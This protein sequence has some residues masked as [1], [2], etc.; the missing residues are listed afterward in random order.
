MNFNVGFELLGQPLVIYI[1]L[2]FQYHMNENQTSATLQPH[3]LNPSTLEQLFCHISKTQ[4]GCLT[5]MTKIF[6]TP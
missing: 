1:A 4:N 3:N 6:N 2:S 5:Q